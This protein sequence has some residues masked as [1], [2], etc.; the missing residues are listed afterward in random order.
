MWKRFSNFVIWREM[1]VKPQFRL[2]ILLACELI[3]HLANNL[4]TCL[5][6]NL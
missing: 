4:L 3:K 6:V 5:L 2:W 1:S